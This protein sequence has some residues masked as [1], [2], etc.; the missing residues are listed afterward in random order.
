[1]GWWASDTATLHFDDVRVPA[2]NMLGEENRGFLSIMN[3]F[4][5]ERMGMVAS[6]LGMMKVC[7]E[8]SV[9]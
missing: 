8:Q 4:N 1:M 6:M 3:N 5:Y 7:L 2:E 9:D